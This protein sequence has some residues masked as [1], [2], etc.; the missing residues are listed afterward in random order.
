M[1]RAKISAITTAPACRRSTAASIR[2]I[3]SGSTARWSNA[4]VWEVTGLESTRT[5]QTPLTITP[6]QFAAA[7]AA[8]RTNRTEAFER[9]QVLDTAQVAIERTA[10]GYELEAAVPLAEIGFKPAAGTAT[11]GDVGVLFG[12]DGGGRTVLRA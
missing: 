8:A 11:R 2:S 6:E 10:S 5:K 9:V 1:R 4:R 3:P 12:T 7:T